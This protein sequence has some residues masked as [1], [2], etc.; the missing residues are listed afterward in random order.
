MIAFTILGQPYSKAN[1][2]RL[3]TLR[4]R[5]ASI[6]S[7]QAL[8]YA[9]EALMQ[10]PPAARRR[11]EGPVCVTMTIWY[12]TQIPDLDESLVL[13]VLQDQWHGKGRDRF[14]L[15]PGVYRNDRQVR[16][17]HIYHRIDRAN[18]RCDIV[19]EPLDA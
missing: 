5:A 14:L 6:K 10:I 17:K 19:V 9:R 7:A 12:A 13:D 2:R 16:E 1:S 11:L 8:N 4:G 15:Q 18:P 3:V